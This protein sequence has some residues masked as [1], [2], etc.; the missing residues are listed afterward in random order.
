MCP[1]DRLLGNL[2]DRDLS[3]LIVD[4]HKMLILLCLT[5]QIANSNGK[6]DYTVLI[7]LSFSKSGLLF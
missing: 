5:Q 1:Q 4:V 7:F 2:A 6:L 3:R